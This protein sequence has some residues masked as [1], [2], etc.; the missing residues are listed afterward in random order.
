MTA[1]IREAAGGGFRDARGRLFIRVT[2]RANH[3]AAAPVPWATSLE[4]AKARGRI[5]QGWVNRL[6]R[7]GGMADL[8]ENFLEQGGLAADEATLAKIALRVDALAG[9]TGEYEREPEPKAPSSPKKLE[10]QTEAWLAS[11]VSLYDERTHVTLTQYAA[12]WPDLFGEA[13]DD[14]NAQ[15]IARWLAMRLGQVTRSTVKKELWGLRAFLTWSVDVARTLPALP[16]FPKL[17]RR[18]L[19]VRAGAQREKPVELTEGQVDGLLAAMSD[20]ARPRYVLMAETGLRPETID[21]LSVP[22]HYTKGAETLEITADIDKARFARTLPLSEKAREVLDAVLAGRTKPGPIF[23]TSRHVKHFKKAAD[24]C[25]LPKETAPYDLRH[26]RGTHGL[27]A[28]GG[29]LNGVAYLLGHKQVTTTNR[30]VHASQRAGATVLSAIA[31]CRVTAAE[32]G[33]KELG[34]TSETAATPAESLGGD[35]RGLNPRQLDPQSTGKTSPGE[36]APKNADLVSE[37]PPTSA[38]DGGL[39][40][41]SAAASSPTDAELERGVLDAVTMGLADVARTL[42]AQLDDRRRARVPDNVVDLSK[43]R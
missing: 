23:G 5:V 16:T 21:G 37:A 2:D 36:S 42:A 28:S 40:P 25:G 13:L 6:R 15:A 17:P 38:G 32:R 39:L 31:R 35:R 24:A 14:L 7:A 11:V 19:G 22:E 3:R 20:K 10:T 41:R 8:I 33:S 34:A 1:K 26:A 18:A 43:R 9:A 29:N 27:E 30:Y 4:E 12:K